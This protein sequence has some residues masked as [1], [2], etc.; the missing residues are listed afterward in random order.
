[1][2]LILKS[3]QNRGLQQCVERDLVGVSS[4]LILR[5]PYYRWSLPL[6]GEEEDDGC[7][8]GALGAPLWVALLSVPSRSGLVRIGMICLGLSSP[9]KV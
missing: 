1:M 5:L 3:T 9:S 2:I 4:V 6:I 8:G 7:G